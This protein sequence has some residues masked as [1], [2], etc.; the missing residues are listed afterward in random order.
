[1]DGFKNNFST[2]VAY[3]STVTSSGHKEII[4]KDLCSKYLGINKTSI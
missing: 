2:S 4:E 1:M 3:Q